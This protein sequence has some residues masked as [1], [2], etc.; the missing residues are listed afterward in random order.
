MSPPPVNAEELAM[1]NEAVMELDII[2]SAEKDSSVEARNIF[3]F[4]M[5]ELDDLTLASSVKMSP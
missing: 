2:G 4:N 5:Q 1:E 3:S